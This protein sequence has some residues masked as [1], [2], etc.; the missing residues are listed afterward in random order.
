MMEWAG[1]WLAGRAAVP[2]TDE[3]EAR[4]EAV[5]ARVDALSERLAQLEVNQAPPTDQDRGS[6]ADW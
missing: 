6:S 1:R 2:T 4:V 5:E 3:I